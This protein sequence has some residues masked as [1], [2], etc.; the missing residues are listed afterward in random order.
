MNVEP[1]HDKSDLTAVAAADSEVGQEL[2]RIVCETVSAIDGADHAAVVALTDRRLLAATSELAERLE[3]IQRTSCS[4]PSVDAEHSG[5]I[6]RINYLS[7]RLWPDF[8]AFCRD[9]EVRSVAALPLLDGGVT[10]GV[11]TVYSSDHH[12]FG[13]PELRIGRNSA[14]ALVTVIRPM[15]VDSVDSSTPTPE[16]RTVTAH[17]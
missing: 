12:A 17:G 16:R 13:A 5:K 15:L 6:E 14:E 8:E 10:I 2:L 1:A 3:V 4:G 7:D 9:C 11:F